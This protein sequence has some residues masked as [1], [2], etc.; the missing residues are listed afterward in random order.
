MNFFRKNLPLNQRSQ[1]AVIIT[2]VIAVVILFIVVF[3][4]ITKVSQ[5][6]TSTSISA[7]KAALGLASQIGSISR[8]Y[9]HTVLHD[10]TVDGKPEQC[11]TWWNELVVSRWV[12]LKGLVGIPSPG[13]T[14]SIPMMGS[15]SDAFNTMSNFNALRESALFQAAISLQSDDVILLPNPAKPGFF[16]EDLNNNGAFDAEPQYD[17]SAIPQ[18]RK[19]NKVD[20]FTAWY[21]TKRLPWVSDDGLKRELDIFISKLKEF[22]DV[23]EWDSTKEWNIKKASYTIKPAAAWTDIPKYDVTCTSTTPCASGDTAC[24]KCPDWVDGLAWP[25]H[26]DE[27]NRRI[28]IVRIDRNDRDSSNNYNTTGGFLKDKFMGLAG[29]LENTSAYGL[30]F[31]IHLHGITSCGDIDGVILDLTEFLGRTKELFDLPLSERIKGV[32]EGWFAR[33]YDFK[34]H[35]EPFIDTNGNGVYD[36]GELFTDTNGNGV[37]DAR[38]STDGKL[39]HDIYLRL[40]R[41]QNFI[42]DWITELETLNKTIIND[43]A[44]A[45]GTHCQEGRGTV[46]TNGYC[47]HHGGPG[48]L[49]CWYSGSNYDGGHPAAHWYGIYGTCTDTYYAYYPPPFP[50]PDH[51]LN[52]VCINGDL[53]GNKPG[54]CSVLKGF[55]PCNDTY[56][57]SC[58]ICPPPPPV[59]AIHKSYYFQGQLSW[60]SLPTDPTVVQFD[61]TSGLTEVGQAIGILQAL[62][63]DIARIQMTI[64]RFADTVEQLAPKKDAVRNQLVYAW[65][66]KSGSGHLVSVKIEGKDAGIVTGYPNQELPYISEKKKEGTLYD[67]CRK[68]EDYEGSFKIITSHYDQDIDIAAPQWKLRRRRQGPFPTGMEFSPVVLD[69]IVEDIQDNG[70]IDSTSNESYIKHLLYLYAINSETRAH[71][72]FEKSAIY[73]M[74]TEGD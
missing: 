55:P 43:V 8:Y 5:V 1:I 12:W 34:K 42:N 3:I 11:N 41:D 27:K 65:K 45:H 28:R 21:Y 25:D 63:D 2:F 54:W 68:L 4:N 57:G 66:D 49:P 59:T 69:K 38:I 33:F 70:K 39:D 13:Y 64:T 51:H 37:Y 6:K 10:S 14:P 50:Q 18:M 7:D 30:T 24:T 47:M 32:R 44:D 52:P 46:S 48:C 40:T 67:K 53:Y 61:S 16:Y 72:G 71:Y 31:C 56:S 58:S 36:A 20:R 62:S 26:F 73:I 35:G 9:A 23:D 60:R 19:Q 15:I 29:R 17:L 74:K 22:V